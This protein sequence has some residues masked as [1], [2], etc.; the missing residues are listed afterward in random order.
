MC[1]DFLCK[2]ETF[3]VL[4]GTERNMITKWLSCKVLLFIYFFQILM[5]LEFSYIF[6]KKP[7]ISNFIKIRPVGAEFFHADGTDLTKLIVAFRNIAN[8]P[9]N[10][11]F[12]RS[13]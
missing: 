13:I 2:S 11:I 1:F 5:K 7:Q 3:P 8:A 9:K 4:R 10:E 6:S 12:T